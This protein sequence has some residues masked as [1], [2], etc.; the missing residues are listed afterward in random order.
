MGVEISSI[1][2]QGKNPPDDFYSVAKAT[3]TG[4]STLT[5][6]HIG[7][8]VRLILGIQGVRRIW[9]IKKDPTKREGVSSRV[10]LLSE[11]GLNLWD[12]CN[13]HLEEL[14]L[15]ERYASEES[16]KQYLLKVCNPNNPICSEPTEE[17]SYSKD[18]GRLVTTEVETPR[19]IFHYVKRS[20]RTVTNSV[21]KTMFDQEKIN[22]ETAKIVK[23][24]IPTTMVKYPTDATM[25][26]R[27]LIA[28]LSIYRSRV[29]SLKHGK[30]VDNTDGDDFENQSNPWE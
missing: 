8:T 30:E 6:N 28:A 23:A 12:S 1:R 25:I 3:A 4:L 27:Q 21:K 9:R 2:P 16:E 29:D 10:L 19:T 18:A 7:A 24:V 5:L 20:N 15:R 26:S 11:G 14:T 22:S 13:C 17:V